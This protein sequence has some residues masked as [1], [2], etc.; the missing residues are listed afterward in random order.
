MKR[1]IFQTIMLGQLYIG[2]E[3]KMKSNLFFTEQIKIKRR[4]LRNLN[5]KS[6]NIKHLE[7]KIGEYLHD[8]RLRQGLNKT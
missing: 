6:S 1:W 2:T 4:W 3:K 8:L 5:I 7:V